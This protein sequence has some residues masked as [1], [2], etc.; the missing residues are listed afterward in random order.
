MDERRGHSGEVCALSLANT[1]FRIRSRDRANRAERLRQGHPGSKGHKGFDGHAQDV[2]ELA[3]AERNP[4][5][6]ADN[7]GVP[8]NQVN[9][10]RHHFERLNFFKRAN[11]RLGGCNLLGCYRFLQPSGYCQGWQMIGLPVRNHCFGLGPGRRRLGEG[12][13][14]LRL[15]AI[16]Q[17]AAKATERRNHLLHTLWAH[18]LH[19]R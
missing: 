11:M 10:L 6:R 12:A 9:H 2:V 15:E 18:E 5:H 7:S 1:N 19:G 3:V 17:R 4:A 16:L 8:V 13:P 14:L